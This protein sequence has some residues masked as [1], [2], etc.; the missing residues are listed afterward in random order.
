[1]KIPGC[2]VPS[3][4]CLWSSLIVLSIVA[5][6]EGAGSVSYQSKTVVTETESGGT[7]RTYYDI[8]EATEPCTPAECEWWKRIRKA[9]EEVNK[10]DNDKAKANFSLLL[11]EGRQKAYRVPLKD[12]SPL[13]LGRLPQLS[14]ALRGKVRGTMELSVEIGADGLVWDVKLI[15]GLESGIDKEVIQATR[16]HIFLPAV[17]SGVFVAE[18]S[19]VERYFYYNPMLR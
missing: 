2:T 14:P 3:S 4:C 6:V 12:R 8:P 9:G 10:K 5:V 13:Y 18:R 15:K 7:V 16:Q 17:R 11:E 19:K 1:M